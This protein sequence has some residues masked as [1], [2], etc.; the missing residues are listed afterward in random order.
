MA[1]IGGRASGKSLFLRHA[2]ERIGAERAF[3]YDAA[4][5]GL[6][7]A[8]A[9]AEAGGRVAILLDNAE[10]CYKRRIGG[11]AGFERL[12]LA[13]ERS[14]PDALWLLAANPAFWYIARMAHHAEAY[15]GKA[16]DLG[17][18]LAEEAVDELDRKFAAKGFAWYVRPD[19]ATAALVRKKVRNKSLAP[20]E[21]DRYIKLR[22]AEALMEAGGSSRG[23][24]AYLMRRGAEELKEGVFIFSFPGR[25]ALGDLD[26]MPEQARLALYS[27]AVHGR[28]SVGE[29]AAVLALRPED[30]ALQCAYLD[31]RG[32]AERSAD[33]GYSVNPRVERQV[34][35]FLARSNLLEGHR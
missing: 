24:R 7:A 8:I 12:L 17:A 35:D 29:T 34:L 15:L 1:V 4:S 26:A 9:R 25:I 2:A 28:L 32:L 18:E 6:E 21:R 5:G 10:L 11:S 13:I 27:L 33:G 23:E 20:R 31:E 30:A 3:S 14:K 16:V 22:Y 19:E